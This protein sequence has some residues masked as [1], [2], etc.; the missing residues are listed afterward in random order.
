MRGRGLSC[1]YRCVKAVRTPEPTKGQDNLLP[2]SLIQG[3]LIQV[4]LKSC[5]FDQ[6]LLPSHIGF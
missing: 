2:W 1:Q 5:A 3:V 6:T 4:S